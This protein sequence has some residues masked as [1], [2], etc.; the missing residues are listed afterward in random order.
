MFEHSPNDQQSTESAAYTYAERAPYH[1]PGLLV[2]MVTG[3]GG[4]VLAVV[5]ALGAGIWL[6][7]KRPHWFVEAMQEV[8]TVEAQVDQDIGN[9]ANATPDD[10]A[11]AEPN[12]QAS[13]VLA[14]PSRNCMASSIDGTKFD[15]GSRGGANAMGIYVPKP[16]K[17]T[18][19][20][21]ARKGSV[22]FAYVAASDG[23]SSTEAHFPENWTLMSECGI[24]RGAVHRYRSARGIEDQ[25]RNFVT[26][27]SGD[28]GELPPAIS[29]DG[30]HRSRR[31]CESYIE[32]LVTLSQTIEEQL[33]MPPVIL[34]SSEFWNDTLKCTADS[35]TA[36]R[37]QALSAYPLWVRDNAGNGPP[38]GHWH[39]ADFTDEGK[40][41]SLG[42]SEVTV[43][44]YNGSAHQLVSWVTGLRQ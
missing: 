30:R 42:K 5:L 29:L 36:Q 35:L 19:W 2:R 40:T 4:I 44:T 21:A 11:D 12:G 7:V 13:A 27:L 17:S 3:S 14:P 31:D 23:R 26:V 25:A 1:R 32:G 9:D 41:V 16:A 43:E 24:L 6:G 37:A 34:T 8:T 28:M 39:R 38:P 10:N 15:I 18:D 33:N 20:A 22:S